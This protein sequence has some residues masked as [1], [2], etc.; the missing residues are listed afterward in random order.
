MSTAQSTPENPILLTQTGRFT[1]DSPMRSLTTDTATSASIAHGST[2]GLIW[3]TEIPL[4]DEC[5]ISH[6][7]ELTTL[8]ICH[9]LHT[10]DCGSMD[11]AG[12]RE[13]TRQLKHL[14][15]LYSDDTLL[16]REPRALSIAMLE[17]FIQSGTGEYVA[18]A[19]HPV[20]SSLSHV[21]EVDASNF[22]LMRP[23]QI[24]GEEGQ[25]RS[26]NSTRHKDEIDNKIHDLPWRRLARHGCRRCLRRVDRD[27]RVM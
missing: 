2:S 14:N 18:D 25:W 1:L 15:E 26:V 6:K 24:K 10:A 21:R 20:A 17:S 5:P 27:M 12:V 13:H 19:W 11:E 23:V 8:T 7:G 3:G 9:P 16:E 4:H 22:R